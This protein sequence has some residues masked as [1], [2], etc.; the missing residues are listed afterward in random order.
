MK[1]RTT[2][3]DSEKIFLVQRLEAKS[4]ETTEEVVA[5]AVAV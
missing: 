4:V 3:K 5:L 1:N 2:D